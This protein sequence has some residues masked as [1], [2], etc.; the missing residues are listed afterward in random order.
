MADQAEKLRELMGTG[1]A[2]ERKAAGGKAA[3]RTLLIDLLV[4][5]PVARGRSHLGTGRHRFRRKLKYRLLENC[6][7]H[8]SGREDEAEPVCYFDGGGQGHGDPQKIV[9]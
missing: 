3:R 6:I 1:S 4:V 9:I 7:H 8:S 5:F 2:R